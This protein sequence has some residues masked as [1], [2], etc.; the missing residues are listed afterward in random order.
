MW[1][2]RNFLQ[3]TTPSKA[4]HRLEYIEGRPPCDE[5]VEDEEVL[6]DGDEGEEA[7]EDGHQPELDV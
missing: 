5:D 6:G 2:V 3:G 1:D 7:P 4:G